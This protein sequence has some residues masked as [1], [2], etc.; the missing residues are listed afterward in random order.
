[1]PENEL[2]TEAFL[3]FYPQFAALPA[4]VTAEYVRLSNG[5]FSSFGED[6][7]E[8][9]RLYT[10]HRLTLYARVALPEGAVPTLAAVAAAGQAQQKIASK[11]V[12]EVAVSY[13]SGSSAASSVSTD[14]ADLPETSF[15]LQLL[16]LIRVYARS[17][18]VP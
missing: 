10:A 17:V 13:S 4:P 11:K 1:M 14:W 5:R 16:S 18:Y 12:G 7:R 9:R 6:A 15:G 8:A 2:T 3:L